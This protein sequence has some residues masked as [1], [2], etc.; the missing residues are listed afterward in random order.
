M[1]IRMIGSRDTFNKDIFLETSLDIYSQFR[2]INGIA[3]GPKIVDK[4]PFQFNLDL[5]KGISFT[6]GSYIGQ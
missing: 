5:L 1:G 4:I 3:E 2:T 6:K